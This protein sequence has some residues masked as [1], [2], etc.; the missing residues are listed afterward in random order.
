MEQ[1]SKPSFLP[2]SHI[3]DVIGVLSAALSPI[4]AILVQTSV[5][6][7]FVQHCVSL[8]V[9]C[10]SWLNGELQFGFF[11]EQNK[12]ADDFTPQ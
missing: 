5:I 11:E 12:P 7:S 10:T 8:Y 1:N 4:L 9:C 3:C 6:F 2:V